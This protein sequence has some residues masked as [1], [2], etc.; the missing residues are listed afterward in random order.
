MSSLFKLQLTY[1]VQ[2]TNTFSWEM[3]EYLISEPNDF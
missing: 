3:L 1:L 2:D